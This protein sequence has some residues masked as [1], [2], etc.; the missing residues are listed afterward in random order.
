MTHT[1]LSTGPRARPRAAARHRLDVA[2]WL[3][4][5]AA[6]LAAVPEAATPPDFDPSA[7]GLD[8][9]RPLSP[10]ERDRAWAALGA[11]GLAADGGTQDLAGLTPGFAA[12]LL[13]LV[14]A[15]VHVDVVSWS[16]RV[17]IHQSTAWTRGGTVAL[18]RRRRSTTPMDRPSG[19]STH[20]NSGRPMIQKGD[21]SG[22]DVADAGADVADAGVDG[23][24]APGRTE[25]E[26]VVE[27]SVA[28]EGGLLPEVWRA[29]PRHDVPGSGGLATPV[30]I[31]WHESAAVAH[32]MR[33]GREDVAAHLSGLPP[34]ALA[35]LGSV[36]TTL[37]GGAHVTLGQVGGDP[38]VH[39]AWLW[40]ETDVVE[41][42]GATQDA[43]VLRRTS[44]DRLRSELLSTLTGLLHGAP[45]HGTTGGGP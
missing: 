1:P 43:V 31:G 28:G 33:N 22:A 41:L 15:R 34:E 20:R 26:P 35:L 13:G 4:L 36:S 11:R 23:A 40:T 16:G 5:R 27:L 25:Q 32:A 44:N 18:A 14:R 8:P 45:D 37:L 10:V 38:R 3:V 19:S 39:G 6:L 9:D 21:P 2:E 7:F 42:L 30:R 29:I 17:G 24:D 12:A